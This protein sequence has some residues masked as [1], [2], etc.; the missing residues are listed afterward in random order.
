[1][2]GSTLRSFRMFAK[3]S[4]ALMYQMNDPIKTNVPLTQKPVKVKLL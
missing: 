3:I 2:V 4:Y 1:M